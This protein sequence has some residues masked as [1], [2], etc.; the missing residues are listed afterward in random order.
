VTGG[1]PSDIDGT[2]RSTIPDADFF[3]INP[4]GVVFGPNASLDVDGSFHVST[5]DEITFP[6]GVFSATD[7]ASSI[8]TTAPPEA[9]GFL[10]ENPAS[11][12]VD[13][14]DLT[15]PEGA[16][17]SLVGG[18][19]TIQGEGGDFSGDP[20]DSPL[21]AYEYLIPLVKRFVEV[22][23]KLIDLAR[24]LFEEQG[25]DS[26]NE[27][28]I[29]EIMEQQNSLEEEIA[30]EIFPEVSKF[31]SDFVDEEIPKIRSF[32]QIPSGDVRLISVAS[33]GAVPIVGPLERADFNGF[34][35]ILVDGVFTTLDGDADRM[36]PGGSFYINGG[37]VVYK[38]SHID[39]IS[40]GDLDGGDITFI[41]DD[42]TLTAERE[43]LLSFFR[44]PLAILTSLFTNTDGTGRGGDITFAADT[45]TFD[46]GIGVFADTFGSGT[47]GDIT[48]TGRDVAIRFS[49]SIGSFVE[50]SSGAGGDVT[51]TADS[52]LIAADGAVRITG[53]TSDTSGAGDAGDVLV[54][55]KSVVLDGL[56]N[57][58]FERG[59]AGLFQNIGLY[60][61]GVA[62]GSSGSGAAGD[63][64]VIARLE[65][66]K[67]EKER[68][69][70]RELAVPATQVASSSRPIASAFRTIHHRFSLPWAPTASGRP[71]LCVAMPATSS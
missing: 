27:E 46:G 45:I 20:A 9:F 6:D 70:L 66:L 26:P 31:D 39:S 40:Y 5:A 10:N 55:A 36:T 29:D 41:A 12:L 52:L 64:T 1:D 24:Q 18:D 33:P 32:L 11:I 16:T 3:M 37:N 54:Q 69:S 13:R 59:G 25:K 8:L 38:D 62:S 34:G 58:E 2:L 4:A 35:N 15:L 23:A 28:I 48:I 57:L 63:V 67:Y 60:R 51:V 53:L 49:T 50:S 61:A 44:Y 68:D 65:S 43:R 22:D 21:T 7:P 56:Q 17:F 30:N 19:I 42:L 47:S 14:S 71:S